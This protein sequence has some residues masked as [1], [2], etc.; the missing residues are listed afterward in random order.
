MLDG[1]DWL[2]VVRMAM[3]TGLG[4]LRLGPT[5]LCAEQ[6]RARGMT[7]AEHSLRKHRFIIFAFA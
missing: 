1:G 2:R 4:A 3:R 6:A 5:T 7:Y